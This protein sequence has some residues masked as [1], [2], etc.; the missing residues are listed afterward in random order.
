MSDA[1]L[2]VFAMIPFGT[3]AGVYVYNRRRSEG[4]ALGMAVTYTLTVSFILFLIYAW[5]SPME[6]CVFPYDDCE[7]TG[8]D[9]LTSDD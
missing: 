7:P 3:F 5:L 6:P 2:V 4:G 9:G 8:V 1:L